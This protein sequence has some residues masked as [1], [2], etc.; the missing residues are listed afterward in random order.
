MLGQTPRERRRLLIEPSNKELSL[1]QQCDL[2]QINRSTL[3]YKAH[4]ADIDD[5][6]LLNEIRD[7]W[8]R[9]PFY[10]YRRITTEL[11]FKGFNVNHKRIQRLMKRG[12]IQAIYPGPNTSR[13]NQLHAVYP[14]L[15]KEVPITRVNQVWMIDITIYAWNP[16]LYTWSH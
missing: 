16:A 15:L 1:R 9:Y 8:E 11:Q 13:R 7:A 5:I 4:G 2:L 6:S 3:Y 14:Y 10:G 12:S